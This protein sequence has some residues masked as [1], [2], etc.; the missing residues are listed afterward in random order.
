MTIVREV[1]LNIKLPRPHPKQKEIKD[2]PAKRK[3]ICAGRQAGKT[4]LAAMAAIESALRGG[5][6]LYAAPT[7]MQTQQVW[8][9]CKTWLDEPISMGFIRKNETDRV[10]E[11]PIHARHN[12]VR[13]RIRCV[14][15]WNASHLRGGHE[16][17][18]ILD[19]FAHMDE[20][21]W[22]M[23]GAPMLLRTNGV[24]W[25]ISTPNRRNHFYKYYLQAMEDGKR[26]QAWHF[27]SHDNPYLSKSALEEITKDMTR[28]EYLQEIMA[29]FLPDSGTVFRNIANCM[30]AQPTTPQE[31][32]GHTIIAGIDWG[33]TNDYTAISIVCADCRYELDRARYRHM[34]TLEQISR[35]KELVHR[36][37]VMFMIP[38]Q[39]SIGMPIIDMILDDEGFKGVRVEPIT[40]SGK[41]KQGLVRALALALEREEFFWQQ[42]PELGVRDP[43]TQELMAYEEHVNP[44]TNVATY[45]APAGMHDDTVV[46]RM[47]AYY[48][49][50]ICA[51]ISI[52]DVTFW[53]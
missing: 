46:A 8:D 20:E 2:S 51:P 43:W 6:V 37:N 45:S 28:S 26:W 35:I 4:T 27:T 18:L 39:N 34:D 11:F 40:V 48:G 50:D 22:S 47:L 17:M 16:N 52:S 15:A 5:H 32:E 44:K 7:A 23:V 13:G 36:W 12:G 49:L 21:V 30:K 29:E 24:A 10:L 14:T 38:E 3:V 53:D 33:R 9:Y 1:R 31:H 42:D 19:E 41:N 25:F